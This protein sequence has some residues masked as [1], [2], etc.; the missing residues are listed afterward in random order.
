MLHYGIIAI[1]SRGDVQPF[2]ALSLG[3]LGKGNRVTLMAH[4]NF[5]SL[6]ESHGIDFHSLAGSTEE[7]LQSPK[8]VRHLQTGN[9][10]RLLRSIH[11]RGEKGQAQVNEDLWEGCLRAEVLVTSALGI[12]WISSIAE[13]MGKRWAIVQLSFPTN[14]T[15]EFPFAGFD[16][17]AFDFFRFPAYNRA[18]F[19]LL[20]S[21]FWRR[22]RVAVNDHRKSLGLPALRQSIFDKADSDHILTCYAVSP[23]LLQ[24]P[25]DWEPNIKVTGFLTLPSPS[26][27]PSNDIADKLL[28]W[29]RTG[30]KPI[31]IGFG[32]MPIPDPARFIRILQELLR[33]TSHRFIFCNG[34]P[35]LEGLPVDSR[36]LVVSS[37]PHEW[38]F[39]QCQA[40]IIHG[41]VGTLAAA[42]K[43]GIPTIVV[44]I[45]GDQHWWGK[46]IQKRKLG[47]H[48]AFKRLSTGKLMAAM[49]N[50][51]APEI[52]QHLADLAFKLNGEDGVR[53]AIDSLEEYF[54]AGKGG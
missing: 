30:E 3:L 31:Y 40:A 26:N 4:E 20:R 27:G 23:A 24:R 10:F 13:K 43:A 21:F 35:D 41:G 48:I 36:L 17:P 18:T 44:S 46:L 51:F 7:I 29:L 25:A 11:Q 32:S 1:G 9:T 50:V 6:V 53:N 15:G 14:S 37:I 42:L 38:L 12:H 54:L 19:W 52:A 47:C 39:P 28:Q 2:V 34:W 5:R 8:A 22:V 45:F 49:Q 33:R 16:F